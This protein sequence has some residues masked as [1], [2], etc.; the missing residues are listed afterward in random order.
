VDDE[1]K[2]KAEE[3]LGLVGLISFGIGILTGVLIGITWG[4]LL[5]Q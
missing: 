3:L 2:R 4:Y 1:R 5:W